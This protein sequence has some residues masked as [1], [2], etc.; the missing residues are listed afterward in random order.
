MN[1]FFKSLE[2]YNSIIKFWK[3]SDSIY[4]IYFG[5]NDS[6]I[7]KRKYRHEQLWS[8]TDDSGRIYLQTL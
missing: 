3:D 1:E 5:F 8:I 7:F 6:R 4:M 2:K